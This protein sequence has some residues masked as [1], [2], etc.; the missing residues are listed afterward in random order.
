[1]AI[2][3]DITDFAEQIGAGSY[4]AISSL[5]LASALGSPSSL[6]TSWGSGSLLV[7]QSGTATETFASGYS[8]TV[9]LILTDSSHVDVTS[10]TLIFQGNQVWSWTGSCIAS[11]STYLSDLEDSRIFSGDDTLRGNSFANAFQGFGGNDTIDGGGGVDTAVFSGAVSD[12]TRT[13]APDGSMNVA[14]PD[15]S[16]VLTN[17]ERLQFNDCTIAFDISGNAGEAYRLYQAAFDRAPDAGGLGYWIGAL[18]KGRSLQEVAANFIVSAEFSTKYGSLGN[19]QFA[20]QLYLNVLHRSPD[21][22]GLAYWQGVLD[23]GIATRA[24]VLAGFSESPEN[25]VNVIGSIEGG[26]AYVPVDIL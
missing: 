26:I 1:V 3:F 7:G 9:G 18:D 20:T 15:G 5:R 23:H 2:S 14:G 13:T 21:P 24:D 19:A 16:D 6:S 25:Q 17:I 4:T 22:G 10:A 8:S 11:R 12:Y